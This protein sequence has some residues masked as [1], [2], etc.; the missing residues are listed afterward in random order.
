M[1]W[2]FRQAKNCFE[3][4]L[5][6]LDHRKDPVM[7]DVCQG[8]A[9]LAEGLSELA[10]MVRETQEALQRMQRM[11]NSAVT[12]RQAQE[13][14]QRLQQ[15][16]AATVG[17]VQEAFQRLQ[18][19]PNPTVVA[20]Q[21]QEALQRMQESLQRIPDFVVALER[22]QEKHSQENH[23]QEKHSNDCSK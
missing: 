11:S 19:M 9:A 2:Q 17:Q 21:A 14:L 20:R 6:Y 22:V 5:R 15:N 23:S 7:W 13:E 16:L 4:A 1:S 8:L 12:V 10:V 3:D 18:Q